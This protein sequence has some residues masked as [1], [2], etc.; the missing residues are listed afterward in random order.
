MLITSG[1]QKVKNIEPIRVMIERPGG[2]TGG[3]D[4]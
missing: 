1:S 3:S 2:G 4:V